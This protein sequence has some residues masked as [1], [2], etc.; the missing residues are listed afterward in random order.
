MSETTATAPTPSVGAILTFK[1]YTALEE[2]QE[3]VFQPGQ[4]LRVERVNEDGGIVAVP[5]EG[6]GPGDTIFPEEVE[7]A[8]T[9]V[10]AKGKK[11]A[12]QVQAAPKEAPAVEAPVKGKG[13]AKQATAE[14]E[15][16]PKAKGKA[17][18][19]EAP[20]EATEEEAPSST[21]VVQIEDSE[22]VQ[23]LLEDQDA[24]AAA[25]TLRNRVEES[26]FSLGGVLNHIVL[27]GAHKAAGFDGKRGFADYVKAELDIDYRKAMYLID[28]YKTFRALGVSEAQF[29]G[30]G[31]SK[32]KEL[33]SIVT[34]DNLDEVLGKARE[35]SK[36]GLISWVKT[37][38][39]N[40]DGTPRVGRAPRQGQVQKT[41]LQFAL[42]ADQAETVTRALEAAKGKVGTD[43]LAQALE[44]IC[45]EWSQAAEGVD[46][47]LEDA[48]RHIEAKYG[49]ALVLDDAATG[50][51]GE[52]TAQQA[53]QAA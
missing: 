23:K 45:A 20:A 26:F 32:A 4:K 19:K 53:Q 5:A 18:A 3:P 29:S 21:D 15:T 37:T 34:P 9:E 40:E 33:T 39:V 36:D 52:E 16:A 41:K 6:N 8:P 30:I 42:F 46:V 51:T 13:K 10:K 31:W 50:E 14:G 43:D 17:K 12:K 49:V 28:I 44:F 47:P 38:F 24:L 25:R 7:A 2:G 48:I 35:L 27:T 11:P 1:G 22:A